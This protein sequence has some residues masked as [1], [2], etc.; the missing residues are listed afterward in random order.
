MWR[1]NVAVAQLSVLGAGKS[2]GGPTWGFKKTAQ[3]LFNHMGKPHK[4]F[5]IFLSSIKLRYAIAYSQ[6]RKAPQFYGLCCTHRGSTGP[7]C[8]SRYGLSRTLYCVVMQN[9]ILEHRHI[10]P[11]FSRSKKQ[12]FTAKK[13]LTFLYMH[14]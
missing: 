14:T 5:Y 6:K 4:F 10:V 2:L 13:L 9:V 3:I 11:I 8:V 1:A 7:Y 12:I